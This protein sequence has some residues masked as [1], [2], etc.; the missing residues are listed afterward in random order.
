MIFVL[1]L[2][3]AQRSLFERFRTPESE[4]FIFDG[5]PAPHIT[6]IRNAPLFETVD[7]PGVV[8]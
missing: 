8:R 4:S 6:M 1:R 2:E 3:I 7:R 5:H